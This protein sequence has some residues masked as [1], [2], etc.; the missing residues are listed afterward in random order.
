MASTLPPAAAAA[1]ASGDTPS[2]TMPAEIHVAESSRIQR[3]RRGIAVT[4]QRKDN[5]RRCRNCD[6][7]IPG[8]LTDFMGFMKG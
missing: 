6:H 7:G 2:V 3:N 4:M 8:L 1:A 5:K